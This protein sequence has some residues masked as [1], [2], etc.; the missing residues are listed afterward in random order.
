MTKIWVGL[1]VLA[2]LV[3]CGSSGSDSSGKSFADVSAVVASLDNYT[4]TNEEF[5]LFQ[6]LL[7]RDGAGYDISPGPFGLEIYVFENEA[8]LKEGV[9]LLGDLLDAFA[10]LGD[11]LEN[12]LGE[13][14]VDNSIVRSDGNVLLILDKADQGNAPTK[15]DMNR[16]I[17]DLRD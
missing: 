14:L 13:P 16:L 5:K 9:K 4:I 3:G 6:A 17:A 7:A 10:P 1:G 8:T 11:S 2:L 15:A 12:L